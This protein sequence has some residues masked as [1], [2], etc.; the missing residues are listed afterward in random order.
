MNDGYEYWELH[1]GMAGFTCSNN[2]GGVPQKACRES[3]IQ[4]SRTCMY[5]NERFTISH[6][7]T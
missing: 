5:E 7:I 3:G 4:S 1:P 6:E 2:H